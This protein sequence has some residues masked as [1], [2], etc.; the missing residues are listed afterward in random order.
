M[1]T[2]HETIQRVLTGDIHAFRQI[3]ETHQDR[4]YDLAFRMTGNAEDAEDILQDSFI[5]IYRALGAYR[6]AYAFSNWAYSIT[7]NTTKNHIRRKKLKRFFSLDFL[8][9]ETDDG[10]TAPL[11]PDT[12][13]DTENRAEYNIA[14]AELER[15]LLR[16]PEKL[17][18]VF[19]L[20]HLHNNSARD[21]ASQLGLSPNAVNIR[22]SRART[23]LRESMTA[24]TKENQ[25]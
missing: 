19:I 25:S 15:Q 13:P 8:C 9:R 18:C 24:N 3:V 11:P 14:R 21:I 17:R 10:E 23:M 1:T 20:Y 12:V 4:L 22:L 5:K 7:L 16:L 2:E 6:P